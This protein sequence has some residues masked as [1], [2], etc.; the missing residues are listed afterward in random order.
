MRRPEVEMKKWMR[1]LLVV[2]MLGVV[3]A[4]AFAQKPKGDD[5]RPPKEPTKV[6]TQD[7][8]KPPPNNNQQKPK[9]NRGRPHD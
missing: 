8:N 9:D 1:D 5:K 6:V 3:A 4:G 2:A 7:K